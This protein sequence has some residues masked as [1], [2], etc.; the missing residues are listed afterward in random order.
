VEDF[1]AMHLR[2][3]YK[4]ILGDPILPLYGMMLPIASAG[5]AQRQAAKRDDD[6]LEA[7]SIV[8]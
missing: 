5:E 3:I 7:D 1:R 4:K 6:V 8:L 2:P